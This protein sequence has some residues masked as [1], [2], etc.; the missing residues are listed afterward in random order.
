MSIKHR[1]LSVDGRKYARLGTR[2]AELD[3]PVTAIKAVVRLNIGKP[4]GAI[5]INIGFFIQLYHC[6]SVKIGKEHASG[7]AALGNCHVTFGNERGSI[8]RRCA[9]QILSYERI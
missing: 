4:T 5:I 1:N 6:P 9:N 8:P 2:I 3:N 7:G